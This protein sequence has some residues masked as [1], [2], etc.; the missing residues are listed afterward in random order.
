VCRVAGVLCIPPGSVDLRGIVP[1]QQA[2]AGQVPPA[3]A[4][5]APNEVGLGPRLKAKACTVAGQAISLAQPWPST[6]IGSAA[7]RALTH[8]DTSL[9]GAQADARMFTLEIAHLL[10]RCKSCDALIGV[11]PP[12]DNWS[13]DRTV[14]CPTCAKNQLG[15]APVPPAPKVKAEDGDGQK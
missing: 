1:A 12:F 7:S 11:R 10:L 6:T 14:L 5:V 9:M 2:V 13:A 4:S 8:A 3:T 15:G